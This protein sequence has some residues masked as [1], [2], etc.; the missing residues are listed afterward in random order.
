MSREILQPETIGI[1]GAMEAEVVTLKNSLSSLKTQNFGKS[2]TFYTGKYEGKDIVLCQSGIG[3]VNAAIATTLLIE[4][5]SPDCVINTGCAG[6]IGKGLKV[7][8]VVIGT[9]V[10]HHDVDVTAFGYAHGQVPQLPVF[11]T[12]ESHLVYAAEV[13]ATAFKN[14]TIS[15]GLIVSGDQFVH[16]SAT[17]Q[18]IMARFPDPQAVEMEAAAIAQTCFQM[19]MPFVVIRAISDGAEEKAEVSFDEFL[20]TA[21]EHSAEMVQAI[22]RSF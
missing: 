6:G 2:F 22:I 18:N 14:A 9:H 1:I 15:R 10:A 7:G 11:Y 3:K 17:T 4:H 20:V 8:D 13:A 5:F 19:N 12:C 16:D 21:S